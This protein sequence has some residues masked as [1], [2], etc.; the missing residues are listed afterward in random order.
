MHLDDAPEGW[1]YTVNRILLAALASSLVYLAQQVFIQVISLNYHKAQFKYKIDESKRD[2]RILSILY[3][4]SLKSFPLNGPD[5][6]TEDLIIHSAGEKIDVEQDGD[7]DSDSEAEEDPATPP[8][9]SHA[10]DSAGAVAAESA[11]AVGGKVAGKPRS[12]QSTVVAALESK[13]ASEAL[14]KRIWTALAASGSDAVFPEDIK[15]VLGEDREDEAEEC[16][17]VLDK[18]TNGDVSFD[19]C[20]DVIVS[21]GVQRRSMAISIHDVDEAIHAL[22]SL[23]SAVAAVVVVFVFSK[24]FRCVHCLVY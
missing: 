9:T 4:A 5:F 22:D 18:N 15:H 7:Y 14:A 16:F 6:K 1:M 24:C 10:T 23:L 19:E 11:V 13:G 3:N 20:V 12:S 21:M 2:I 17:S 8:P